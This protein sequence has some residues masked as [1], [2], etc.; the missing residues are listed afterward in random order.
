MKD[1]VYADLKMYYVF[2]HVINGQK[3]FPEWDDRVK[4][5]RGRVSKTVPLFTNN[6]YVP[7]FYCIG[8][9]RDSDRRNIIKL[10]DPFKRNT[11]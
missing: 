11:P 3:T 4:Y 2:R 10:G 7:D 9:K 6:D 1:T 8:T 5:Y